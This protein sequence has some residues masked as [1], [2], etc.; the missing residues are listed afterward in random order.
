MTKVRFIK[1]ILLSLVWG[2]SALF[3]ILFSV[4]AADGA[5]RYDGLL[6][7]RVIEPDS[8]QYILGVNFK[9]P[10]SMPVDYVLRPYNGKATV[11]AHKPFYEKNNGEDK[12][13]FNITNK[14]YFSVRIREQNDQIFSA[15][16]KLYQRVKDKSLDINKPYHF[17]QDDFELIEEQPID[18]KYN[19]DNE[20]LFVSRNE[21]KFYIKLNFDI[22]FTR[23]EIIERFNQ[24][25]APKVDAVTR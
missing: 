23:Q 7:V 18:G 13:T 20:Y 3:S 2:L 5:F 1:S 12:R 15:T 14:Y 11:E 4:Q 10:Y 8:G 17:A 19:I 6:D 22:I 25:T 9:S 21:L 24:Q 16:V